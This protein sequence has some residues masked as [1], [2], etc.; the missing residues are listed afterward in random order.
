MSVQP[1][2][3]HLITDQSPKPVQTVF[4]WVTTIFTLGYMLPWAIAATRGKSNS[5]LIGWLTFLLGWS[6]I[7][8]VI[9]LVLACLPHQVKAVAH[10]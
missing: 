7:G 5:G 6:G 3:S 2:M 1:H 4:G 8:W 9:F 10:Y